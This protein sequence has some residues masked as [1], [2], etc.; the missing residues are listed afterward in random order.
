VALRIGSRVGSYEIVALLG[1]GGMGEVYCARDTK[2]NRDVAL[3]IL[4]DSFAAD[5]D[6]FARFSR[7]AQTLA[8]LS[9]AGIAMLYGIEDSG[10]T[11]ALVME[12]AEGE[13]LSQRIA[14]GRIPIDET[15]SI[16]RQIAAALAAA[17]DKGIIHRDLKPA[18]IKVSADNKVKILD[19]GLAKALEQGAASS[20][21]GT[22]P[23][24]LTNSPTLT[25][26]LFTG[27]GVILGTAAYMSPEQAR[28]K[29]VDKRTDIWAFGCVLF[30]MLTG[31]RPFAADEVSDT[32]AFIL[33][34]EP[35]WEA[36]PSDT[37][38]A[39]RRL[40]RRCLVKDRTGRLADIADA[41][42][43]IDEARSGDADVRERGPAQEA[44]TSS[45]RVGWAG[46][47][48][49]IAAVA[50]VVVLGAWSASRFGTS[51]PVQPPVRFTIVPPHDHPLVIS[52]ADRDIAI[53]PDGGRI[54]YRASAT[55]D[56]AARIAVRALDQLEANLL[57]PAGI[58]EP[59][60]SPDGRWIAF[61]TPNELRKIAITGGPSVLIC[62]VGG[63]PRGASWGA[64][65]T[66]V[67]TT[68]EA[69]AGL[70]AVS[71]KGG[72][73]KLLTTPE[74]ERH[75]FPFVLPGEEAVLYTA[76]KP[77]A[78]GPSVAVFDRQTGRSKTLIPGASDAAYVEDERGG[79]HG[80][81]VYGSG[82]SLLAARF[83]AT[84]LELESDPLPLL[85]HMWVTPSGEAYFSLSRT[86]TLVYVQA[87]SPVMHTQLRTLLWVDR[88]GKEEETTAPQRPYAVARLS[89]D[90]TRVALD[91]RDQANDIYTWDLS[92][93]ALMPLN[94]DPMADLSPVWTPDSK[95]IIWTSTRGSSNPNL[96]WQLADG[97]GP[98]ERLSTSG[99]AQFPTSISRDGMRLVFFS[100]VAGAAT[101]QSSVGGANTGVP[102]ALELLTFQNGKPAS[103]TRLIP[104]SSSQAGGE[105]S[106]DGRWLA[107]ESD[108]AGETEV[109]V[110]PFPNVEA[111]RV[112]IS[113]NGGTRP[114]WAHSGREL[115]YLDHEGML[116][117][118][119]VAVSGDSLTAGAPKRILDKA[120]YAGSTTRGY[121]LRSWDV[122]LD[123]QRFLMIKDVPQSEQTSEREPDPAMTVVLHWTEE[124]KR[125]LPPK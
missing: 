91:V 77:L 63:A 82:N 1:A 96:Y 8:S 3:K 44:A 93:K 69:P 5:P 30:E 36:L 73:S 64:D 55:T 76:F 101:G 28:G 7:E 16:A 118:V 48:A 32:L 34:K 37:P 68:V 124:L 72:D 17:H 62:P 40:L 89:P 54:A 10:A 84:R 122:S 56:A 112:Q 108:E 102:S 39:L 57:P 95:R 79:G 125:L 123:D 53:A 61:F 26:P 41:C 97:S 47:L 21:A 67:F 59:F 107:Y 11:H 80:Y 66:I 24:A 119:T 14:R 43:D 111:S 106:P 113:T 88:R 33:T 105:I 45:R 58:R 35:D 116:T 65:D 114:A 99:S 71:A 120:Y 6:R 83:N 13:D 18:N 75:E 81:I 31:H 2:L 9:H 50:A 87:S 74:G 4:P 49:A 38:V 94:T 78:G 110:R 86:G 42:L 109:F 92:R 117:S 52:P 15:L 70:R 98:W 121:D 51:V 103:Q 100:T 19:F 23:G 115:F 104:T 22:A 12:L 27:M 20:A 25:S 85:E 90:G 46:P 29:A 60:F